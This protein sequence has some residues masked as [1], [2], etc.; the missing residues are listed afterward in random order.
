MT[1]PDKAELIRLANIDPTPDP[2]FVSVL[3]GDMGSRKTTTAAS[4]VKERGL[5]LSSD[6]SWKVLLNPEH[7]ALYA[8]LK[9]IKLESFSQFEY[10]DF[11]PPYDTVIWDTISHSVDA[12]LDLLYD[13]ASWSGTNLRGKITTNNTELKKLK[14]ETLAPMDYRV[15]RDALRPILNR[16]F[17]TTTAH[18]VFTSQFKEPVPG[19]SKEPRIRPDIPAATFKPIGTRADII[20]Y[21]KGNGNN[22]TVDVTNNLTQLGKSRI[23]SIQG[24]MPQGAFVTAYK[25]HVFK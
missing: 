23:R 24:N 4:M 15:T 3:Y 20:G 13:E 19:L 17:D 1:I 14:L 2:K 10:I 25:E 22:Y 21:C 9:V 11:S 18:L 6:D 16:L 12:F 7:S 8:K 5:L